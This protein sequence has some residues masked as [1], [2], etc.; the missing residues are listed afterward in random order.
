MVKHKERSRLMLFVNLVSS[1][2]SL[3]HH[4]DPFIYCSHFVVCFFEKSQGFGFSADNPR[5]SLAIDPINNA[6][7]YCG[8]ANAACTKDLDCDYG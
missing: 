8:Y 4:V 5:L 2:P 7:S 3:S 1:P 6:I